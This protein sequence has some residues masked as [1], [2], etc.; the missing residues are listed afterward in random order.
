WFQSY[1]RWIS[2]RYL[3]AMSV[4]H[5][6]K[7][8]EEYELRGDEEEQIARLAEDG[9]IYNKLARSL[10]PKTFGHEDIKKALFL[11]LV[12]A[13]HRKLK[14]GM[15]I[16][17]NLHICLMGD[18]GV[19]KSQLLKHIINIAPRGVYTTGKGS[20]GVGLTAVVQKDPITNEMLLEGRAL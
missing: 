20:S 11:L 18:P 13:P 9:D 14:D 2:C 4:T 15:K 19:T 5:F 6:K 17:G 1:V 10:A 12:G 16:R 7:L 8:Y 3:E